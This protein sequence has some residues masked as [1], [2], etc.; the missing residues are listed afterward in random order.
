VINSL[1]QAK[2]RLIDL[3]KSIKKKYSYST[4]SG[5]QGVNDPLSKKLGVRVEEREMPFD[6]GTYLPANPPERPTAVICLDP[7]AG[8]REH[9]N[10]S[11]FHEISHH[12]IRNDGELYSF[13]ND[14]ANRNEDFN[15]LIERFA[16]IGAAEFLIPSEEIYA[17]LQEHGF[18]IRLLPELDQFYPASKPAIAIQMAQCASHQCFVVVCQF[19]IIPDR[20]R[21]QARL[22][23][24]RQNPLPCLFVQ[25]ASNSPS[26]NR[27]RIAR[28]SLITYNHLFNQAYREQRYYT[29]Q[30]IIPFKSGTKWKVDCEALFYM[31]KVYGVLNITSP[32]NISKIQPRL[33]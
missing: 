16:N 5:Y 21:Q 2:Q 26:Q 12:I 11:F 17:Y 18:S 27:Y 19:G 15:A 8:D 29:G 20:N 22:L 7:N 4:L 31:G 9:L 33:F 24:D 32:T 6:Y 10:F 14:L 1:Q 23:K 30:D 25:Y 13:L 28:Y 3:V